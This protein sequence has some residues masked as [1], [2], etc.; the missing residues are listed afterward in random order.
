MPYR[1][2]VVDDAPMVEGFMQEALKK[3]GHEVAG[4]ARTGREGV[5]LYK[6]L[7]PDLVTMDLNMPDMN[8]LDA[9]KAIRAHDPAARVLMITALNQPLLREDL[10]QAGALEVLGKPIRLEALFQMLKQALEGVPEK[11]V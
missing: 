5:D 7:H 10:I 6:R 9:L 1:V 8:G 4:V 11:T 3:A 2:L